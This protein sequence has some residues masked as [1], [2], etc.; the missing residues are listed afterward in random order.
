VMRSVSRNGTI[1][2]PEG[3][4]PATAMI[5]ADRTQLNL[6]VSA[7]N[8]PVVIRSGGGSARRRSIPSESSGS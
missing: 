5:A 2:V 6:T 4:W 7:A 1:R 8:D 3:G